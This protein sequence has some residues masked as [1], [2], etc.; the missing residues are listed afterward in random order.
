MP[1]N[2]CI[3]ADCAA[4][5]ENAE[6][7]VEVVEADEVEE[8]AAATAGLNDE[9]AALAKSKLKMRRNEFGLEGGPTKKQMEN[10]GGQK[11]GWPKT[12]RR[13]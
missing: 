11:F 2:C 8:Q 9:E 12:G 4:A 10:L 6:E 1:A 5:A 3:A 13:E 7:A